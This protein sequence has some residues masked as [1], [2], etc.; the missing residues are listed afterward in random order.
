MLH[1]IWLSSCKMTARLFN[2]LCKLW[3]L[4]SVIKLIWKLW[5][6]WSEDLDYVSA[7]I[8]SSTAYKMKL[9]RPMWKVNLSYRWTARAQWSLHIHAVSP[10]P[11][12][13]AQTI[14]ATRASL[15]QKSR[16]S[17]P[18]HWLRVP[19][20]RIIKVPFIVRWLR[21][22]SKSVTGSMLYIWYASQIKR[23]IKT[24]KDLYDKKLFEWIQ[25]LNIICQS[26]SMNV[27]KTLW[28]FFHHSYILCLY[29]KILCL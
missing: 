12:L 17:S 20:W 1:Y 15:R 29:H 10:E 18:T 14:W 13:F 7:L 21:Y 3:L 24:H 8:K 22:M 5:S 6:T 28:Q 27:T 4:L 25:S 16:G 2:T 11:S 23:T 19:I 9:S 26:F